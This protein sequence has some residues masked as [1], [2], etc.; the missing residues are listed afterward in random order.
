MLSS[1]S[2]DSTI[3]RALQ[4][5]ADAYIMKPTTIEELEKAMET[6]LQKHTSMT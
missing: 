4:M 3:D 6:A 2:A 5:G 1:E